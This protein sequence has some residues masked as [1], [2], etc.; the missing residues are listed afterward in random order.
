MKK[1]INLEQKAIIYNSDIDNLYKKSSMSS[2]EAVL[3]RYKG[4]LETKIQSHIY[5]NFKN[6]KLYI[7][8][9]YPG[10]KLHFVQFDNGGKMSKTIERGGK[11]IYTGRLQKTREGTQKGFCDLGIFLS[12]SSGQFNQIIFVEAKRVGTPSQIKI[13][14]EQQ[15]W[16]E[17]LN[18]MGWKCHITNNPLYFSKIICKEIEAF[19]EYYK[20]IK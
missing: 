17:E 15:S 20:K 1:E 2:N 3:L 13:N 6:F 18:S 14:P 7:L 12:T 8:N 9:K 16:F 19:F 4:A 11:I 5:T 10:A